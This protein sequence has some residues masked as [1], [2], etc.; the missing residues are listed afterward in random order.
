MMNWTMTRPGVYVT[1]MS[2]V[3]H[4]LSL[5]GSFLLPDSR[6]G[7]GI[8]TLDQFKRQYD[9]EGDLTQYIMERDGLTFI[10]F[11]D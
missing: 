6:T 3:E 9:G 5:D 4:E 1:E 11:N 7:S 8:A 10:I 2:E